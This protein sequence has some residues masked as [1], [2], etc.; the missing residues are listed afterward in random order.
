MWLWFGVAFLITLFLLEKPRTHVYV[1]FTPW[2]LIAGMAAERAWLALRRANPYVA[3]VWRG[4]KQ[5]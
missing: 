2:A 4:C 5:G 1:F 3:Q